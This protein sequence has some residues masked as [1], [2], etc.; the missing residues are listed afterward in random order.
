MSCQIYL[1]KHFI[2]FQFNVTVIREH[3]LKDSNPLKLLETYFVALLM[4]YFNDCS[5]WTSKEYYVVVGCVFCIYQLGQFTYTFVVIFYIFS[6]FC[7]SMKNISISF[8][9]FYS[10]ILLAFNE[11]SYFSRPLAFLCSPFICGLPFN[12][13]YNVLYHIGT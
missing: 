13:V 2:G 1:P 6:D 10:E 8:N 12:P 3:S 5:M 7:D 9:F 11:I 4:V